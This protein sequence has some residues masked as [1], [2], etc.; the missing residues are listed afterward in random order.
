MKYSRFCERYQEWRKTLEPTLRQVH[1]PGEKMFVNWIGADVILPQQGAV[2]TAQ[3]GVEVGPVRDRRRGRFRD[4]WR[5]YGAQP[6]FQFGFADPFGQR[7]LQAR[8]LGPQEIIADRAGG[9][10]TTSCDFAD[11]QI[12]FM[13]Q[14]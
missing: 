10:T 11:R 12:V 13:F 5:R 1:V 7:P 3:F 14:T 2:G 4:P 8:R 6:C 9:D